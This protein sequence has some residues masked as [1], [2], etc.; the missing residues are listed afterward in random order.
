M[1]ILNVAGEEIESADLSAGFLTEERIL[2]AHHPAT[3]GTPAIGHYEIIREYPNGGQDVDFVV[4]SPGIDGQEAW[5]EYETILRYTEYTPEQLEAIKSTPTQDQ[6]I[7]DLEEALSLLL[8][9]VTE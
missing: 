9:G 1:K 5:D 3:P 7:A 4:D 8:S 6:R 2:I